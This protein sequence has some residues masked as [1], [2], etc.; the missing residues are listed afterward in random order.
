M[1]FDRLD[2]RNTE[3]ESITND[4]AVCCRAPASECVHLSNRV[5]LPVRHTNIGC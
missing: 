3:S 1:L 2:V 5:K 4:Q